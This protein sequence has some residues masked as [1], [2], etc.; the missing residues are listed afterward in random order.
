MVV[1]SAVNNTEAVAGHGQAE[2]RDAMRRLRRVRERTRTRNA[3]ERTHR[4]ARDLA[5]YQVRALA[6]CD[7]TIVATII[8][9]GENS[10]RVSDVIVVLYGR[11][12]VGVTREAGLVQNSFN[13]RK[14][15][16]EVL[17]N[18]CTINP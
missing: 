14:T 1:A 12:R 7:D 2:G 6:K 18:S 17:L 11:P 15:A 3:A 9:D 10:E 13:S 16:P 8:A 4:S 5:S